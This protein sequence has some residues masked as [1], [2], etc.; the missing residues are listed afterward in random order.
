M[1]LL[2]EQ[3]EP[4]TIVVCDAHAM[5]RAG[6]RLL[7]ERDPN[8][9]VL[10]DVA[11]AAQADDCVEGLDPTVVVLDLGT[12][13]PHQLEPVMRLR[14]AHPATAIVTIAAAPD[15]ELAREALRL[16]A[17]GFVPKAAPPEQLLQAVRAAAAGRTY[18][19][20]ELGAQLAT[21]PGARGTEDLTRREVEV[22]RLIAHGHTNSE[23]ATQ[24]VLSV[25]TIES[26]RARIQAKLKISG[27]AGL[28]AR[29]RELGLV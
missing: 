17:A 23:I 14:A 18:L 2:P 5:V 25:R 21:D 1:A 7:L 22:L 29:A 19:S 3:G 15:A 6:L 13:S 9:L 11:T 24:L 16:G 8:L 26:H 4:V 27:R 28:V 12:P 10:A 20:P